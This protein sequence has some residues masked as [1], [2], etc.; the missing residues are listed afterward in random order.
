MSHDKKNKEVLSAAMNKDQFK[1]SVL[2]L[3]HFSV[4][5]Y[6]ICSLRYYKLNHAA[7]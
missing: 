6:E 2:I 4:I 1:H 3:V 7:T 5:F